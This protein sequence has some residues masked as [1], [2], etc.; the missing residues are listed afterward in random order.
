MSEWYSAVVNGL[1]LVGAAAAVALIVALLRWE[2]AARERAHRELRLAMWQHAAPLDTSAI[3]EFLGEL[4]FRR[5]IVLEGEGHDDRR[6]N[7]LSS[8]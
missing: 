6:G 4:C 1:P 7:T 5:G 3:D 2:D 8:L